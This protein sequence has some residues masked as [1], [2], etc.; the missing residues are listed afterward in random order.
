MSR[1][2]T[3]CHHSE[4]HQINKAIIEG[5]TYRDIA[6]AWSLSRSSLLR[7]AQN[8]LP[9]HLLQSEK[10]REFLEAESIAAG[11][12]ELE[13]DSR[14]LQ[15]L[16]ENEKDFKSAL[17]ALRERARLIELKLKMSEG[18]N[19][20]NKNAQYNERSLAVV[21]SVQNLDIK[22]MLLDSDIRAA[23]ELLTSKGGNKKDEFTGA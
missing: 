3:V 23:I 13:A 4:T 19:A 17:A 7:H 10:A 20:P 11:I 2:C 15:V 6:D 5:R 22:A 9:R 18:F 21:G 16:A 1:T 8:H 14:R 12:I